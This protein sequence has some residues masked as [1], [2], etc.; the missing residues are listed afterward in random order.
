MFSGQA[1]SFVQ[2]ARLA[3]SLSW[4]AGY[5]N[6]LT[7]LTCH[8][9]TSHMTGPVSELGIDIA[10]GDWSRAAYLSGV[11]VMFLAG[12]FASGVMTEWGRVRRYP[13]I[14]VLPMIVE[15]LLL[16]VFALLVD[17]QA[18]GQLAPENAQVWLTFLPAFA[19]G[20][21]NATITRIS[22]GVVR[23][24]HVTGVITDLGLELARIVFGLFGFGRKLTDARATAARWRT[25]LLLSIPG[26][27]AFGAGLGTVAY[28]HVPTWSMVPPCVFLVFLMVRDLLVPIA[29]VDLRHGKHHGAPIVAI[30]HA[31]P[32]P[33]GKRFR[34][35]D[36]TT[37][38][39][40]IDDHVRVVVLDLANVQGMGERSALELRALML[41]LREEGRQLV[42]AGVGAT[43][44]ATMQHAGVLL[45]FDADDLCG[46]LH[47][48]ALRAER[49]AAACAEDANED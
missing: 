31:E 9:V 36:L 47:S 42:L 30:F 18:L 12:A 34:L 46:D 48:A 4:I 14:Y 27:F 44:L 37:W 45:D 22:G 13:S 19:M 10:K 38:A 21:Q 15:A 49:L 25:L 24:T 39:S 29:A 7:V 3:I 17:W 1:H 16:A 43:Q 6:A 35:P 2:Q 33:P 11:V 41:H 8:Q 5:T 40:N 23:T 20:L 26:S 28:E 32:P